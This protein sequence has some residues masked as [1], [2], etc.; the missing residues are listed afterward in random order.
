[1]RNESNG[2]SLIEL[3]IAIAIV[4][5]LAAIAYPAYQDQVMKSRRADAKIALGHAAQLQERWFT[6]NGTYSTTIS[7]IGGNTSDEGYYAISVA[8]P[9]GTGCSSGSNVYC[10]T[11]T[12]TPQAPQNTDTRCANFTLTHT[13][14]KGVSGT[15]TAADCW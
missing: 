4:G 14:V 7:D 12:A 2:F 11:L 3:M 8:N 1:M 15:L 6:Q 10:Y 13:G 5:I 9:G